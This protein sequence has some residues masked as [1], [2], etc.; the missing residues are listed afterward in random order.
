MG[1]I[2]CYI[3]LRVMEFEVSN[4]I[5]NIP[6]GGKKKSTFVRKKFKTN[7]PERKKPLHEISNS[8]DILFF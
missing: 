2:E 1:T 7:L 5:R 4:N 3:V 8:T 6:C